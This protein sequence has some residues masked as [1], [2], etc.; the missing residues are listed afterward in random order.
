MKSYFFGSG[1]DHWWL[2]I[3]FLGKNVQPSSIEIFLVAAAIAGNDK[4]KHTR[5]IEIL[6]R[7]TEC[8]THRET[9]NRAAHPGSSY[10]SGRAGT[11]R[12]IQLVVLSSQVRGDVRSRSESRGHAHCWS[13]PPHE[14]GDGRQVSLG[15]AE[16]DD[17]GQTLN[18]H[19]FIIFL[20][21]VGVISHQ[22]P[23]QPE[24]R[25]CW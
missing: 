25:L 11:D 12:V 10:T 2:S 3:M 9:D 16:H 17:V 8:D 14:S 18:K 5:T 19:D 24:K 4:N 1:P 7:L 22:L 23:R 6:K 20:Q 15:V 21:Q 13:D